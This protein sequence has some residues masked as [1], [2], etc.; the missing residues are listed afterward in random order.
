MTTDV[1]DLYGQLTDR[2]PSSL[3][4]SQ[5]RLVAI[6]D[7]RQEVDAGGFGQLLPDLGRQLRP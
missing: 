6:C 2:D 3:T 4:E 5:R 1:W 7:L